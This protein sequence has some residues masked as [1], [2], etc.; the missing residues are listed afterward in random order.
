[1]INSQT[2][3]YLK[4][5]KRI[6]AYDLILELPVTIVSYME[7]VSVCQKALRA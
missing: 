6:T 4:M 5:S 2:E 7:A 1:M 3:K